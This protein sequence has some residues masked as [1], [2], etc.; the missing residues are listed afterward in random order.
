M[1]LFPPPTL[2]TCGYSSW[3]AHTLW[4]ACTLILIPP[5]MPSAP[6]SGRLLC[7][8]GASRSPFPQRA[9]ST[10]PS[11]PRTA[12]FLG[13]D[14]GLSS[15][16]AHFLAQNTCSVHVCSFLVCFLIFIYLAV[17]GLSCGMQDL[18][19]CG[20]QDLVPDQGSNPGPLLWEHRVLTT[21]PPGKPQ[22]MFF[23]WGN[24]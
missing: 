23:K 8:Q 1:T 22:Y 14:L 13:H 24:S 21:G 7:S 5:G 9:L 10:R 3:N 6:E 20:M 16:C 4:P 2:C 12:N 11:S 17:P 15:I 19:S 18:F